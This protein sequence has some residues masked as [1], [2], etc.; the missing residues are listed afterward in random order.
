VN[1]VEAMAGVTGRPRVL[2]V[3]TRREGDGLLVIVQDSGTG[4]AAESA[5]HIFR[6]FFT[7]KPGGMGMGLS[8]STTII[9]AHG[10]RLWASPA[11]GNGT[12]FHFTRPSAA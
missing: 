9:E 11:P 7:T 4:L 3:T 8:I 5:E 2:T 6:P 12:A 1:A 10:G